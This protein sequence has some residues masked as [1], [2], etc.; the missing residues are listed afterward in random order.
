[1]WPAER[2]ASPPLTLTVPTPLDKHRRPA[3]ALTRSARHLNT[4]RAIFDVG[5]FFHNFRLFSQ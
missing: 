3:E 2:P 5:D 1:M 4:M